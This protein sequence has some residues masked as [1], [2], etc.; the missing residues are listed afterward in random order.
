M[1]IL[2]AILSF[3]FLSLFMMPALSGNAQAQSVITL[4]ECYEWARKNYPLIQQKEL[5]V[6]SLAY[7]IDNVQS[8]HLPQLAIYAQATYQS[9]VTRL[10]GPGA[11]VEPL[12]KD[13][14][15]MYAELNQSIYDGGIIKNQNAVQST[16]TLVEQ[17][18][19]EVEL[20][21]IKDRI[22]QIFFGVLLMEAQRAQINLLRADLTTSLSRTE[23]AIRNGTAFRTN[24]DMLQAELLKTDQRI[25]EINAC[26]SVYLDML[27]YFINQPL[28]DQTILQAPLALADETA[29]EI[30]RP[31]LTLYQFQLELVGAQYKAN[32]TRNVPK[33]GLF[34]QGG[35]GRPGLNMLKNEFDTYYQGGVRFSWSLGNFYNSKRD[36]ELLDVNS[37][38]VNTQRETFLF[39]TNLSLKQQS[40][41]VEKLRELIRVDG[42][43][44]TLRTRIKNTAQSQYDNGVIS[45]SDLLRELNAEETARQ[46]LAVHQIQWMLAKYNYQ[47]TSGN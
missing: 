4:E 46:N 14:Y 9:E 8:G 20:Y 27:G 34:L 21:K 47:T 23:S 3:M 32:Q 37:L 41:E 15:R 28:N 35:Y 6:R 26:R 12:S 24:A 39:N 38:F 16:N 31:E 36:R 11:L 17:Q 40:K 25:I 7:N 5:L 19:L 42:D 29:L 45:T 13:Q 18:K 2:N 33:L 10:P 1:R 30:R 22:N 43:I 44:I